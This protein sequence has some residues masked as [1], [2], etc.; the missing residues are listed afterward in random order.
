MDART[1]IEELLKAIDFGD[2]QLLHE[3][4][5]KAQ[6]FLAEP[7][8]VPAKA[9]QPEIIIRCGD[10]PQRTANVLRALIVEIE[11]ESKED[12]LHRDLRR[13]SKFVVPGVTEPTNVCP[14]CG[15][16]PHHPLS[17]PHKDGCMY[18]KA[19]V[20]PDCGETV[21]FIGE[22]ICLGNSQHGSKGGV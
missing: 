19:S 11:G 1:V 2:P 3:A 16:V 7:E 9:H 22:Y 21:D 12:S 10:D 4:V 14:D 20:C 8:P 18:E 6:A 15:V 13:D 5:G 17:V